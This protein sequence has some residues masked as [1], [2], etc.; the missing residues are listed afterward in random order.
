MPGSSSPHRGWLLP[1]RP[2]IAVV[3]AHGLVGE[4]LVQVLELRKFPTEKVVEHHLRDFT[5]AAAA[6]A[7]LVFLAAPATLSLQWAKKL[8]HQGCI[9]IDLSEAWRLDYKVPLVLSG[10]NLEALQQHQGL[11]A[12]PNCTNGG[13]VH[14]LNLLRRHFALK[15]VVVTTFQAASGGGRELLEALN[16]PSAALH[17]N[18]IPQCD[19]FSPDGSTLEELRVVEESQR[20]LGPPA[21]EIS[22]TCVRVPVAVGHGLSVWMDF[23]NDLSL[24]SVRKILGAEDAIVLAPRAADYPTP[25]SHSGQEG[26]FVGRVRHGAT[27]KQLQMWIV[28]DNLLT[29]AASNA[30]DLAQALLPNSQSLQQSH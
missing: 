14:V 22:A 6:N 12:S 15:K 4:A 30:V 19:S 1:P 16:Q 21:V 18:V 10:H 20:L 29:G 5:P 25:K 11:I 26:V 2:R 7:D 13:L 27:A 24:E 3:G 17:A 8:V 28:T 9:V 23:E